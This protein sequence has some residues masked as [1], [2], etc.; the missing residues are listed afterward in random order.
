MASG[1]HAQP[2]KALGRFLG[3]LDLLVG[4]VSLGLATLLFRFESRRLGRSE[5]ANQVLVLL[6]VMMAGAFALISAR[7]SSETVSQSKG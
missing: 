7:H 6:G 2:I 5:G 3:E 4:F 1:G